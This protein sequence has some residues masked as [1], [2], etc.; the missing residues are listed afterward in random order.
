MPGALVVSLLFR[1]EH[2]NLH[3]PL[4][5]GQC[6]A[7]MEAKA[8]LE[9]PGRGSGESWSW[10]W[11][12][13]RMGGTAA[14][15]LPLAAQE[16]SCCPGVSEPISHSGAVG[17]LTPLLLRSPWELG[18]LVTML[19]PPSSL[20]WSLQS[21]LPGHQCL[22]RPPPCYPLAILVINLVP[23]IFPDHSEPEKHL[24]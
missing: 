23:N 7:R 8:L 18:V 5:V 9:W 17:T 24:G 12:T 15:S 22:F 11:R 16:P 1:L 14:S 2:W 19:L 3:W 20:G 21:R 6:V 10:C 4:G 13:P